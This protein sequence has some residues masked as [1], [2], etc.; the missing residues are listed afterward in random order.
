MIP[1][2]L[3]CKSIVQARYKGV[4]LVMSAGKIVIDERGETVKRVKHVLIVIPC[5][6]CEDSEELLSFICG[7]AFGKNLITGEPVCFGENRGSDT[8]E[9]DYSYGQELHKNNGL[10]ETIQK[11]INHPNSRRIVNPLFKT[12]HYGKNE[13]PCM[14][15]LIWDIEEEDD[16]DYLNL[17]ILGRS[18]EAAIAMKNDL[19]GYSYLLEYVAFRVGVKP[20][21]IL[22]HDV[23]LHCRINSDMDEIKRILK[24][25]Y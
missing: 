13:V 9:P 5:T 17:T 3:N 14:V 18:N 1:T 22:L 20:G 7:F 12:E 19:K 4:D 16:G 8:Q 23:N 24:A 6:C 11:L 21:I 25:G 15:T 2:V 10:E